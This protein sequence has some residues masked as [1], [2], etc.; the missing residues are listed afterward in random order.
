MCSGASGLQW[1]GQKVASQRCLQGVDFVLLAPDENFPPVLRA[2]PMEAGAAALPPLQATLSRE[3]EGLHGTCDWGLGV[4]VGTAGAVCWGLRCRLP[5]AHCLRVSRLVA[6]AP[7]AH[8]LW[9][10][11][12][13]PRGLPK[14]TFGCFVLTLL[15]FCQQIFPFAFARS[16]PPPSLPQ[17]CLGQAT[18]EQTPVCWLA[19]VSDRPPGRS[20]RSRAQHERRPSIC[21]QGKQIGQ[22]T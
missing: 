21:R 15:R 16:P 12:L 1:P 11:Y 19:S 20:P 13:T 8:G 2:L 9:G 3:V 10:L 4:A 7:G 5:R 18:V 6:E 22:F 14:G 17:V